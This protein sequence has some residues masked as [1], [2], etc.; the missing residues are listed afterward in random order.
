MTHILE[1]LAGGD[2]RSIGRSNEAV[3][4][5]LEN[6]ELFDALFSGLLSDDPVI[7]MRSADAVE[8]VTAIHPEYLVS[9]KQ[10]LLNT[11]ARVEQ[12]KCAGM[13]HPCW[14][15]FRSR[16]PSKRWWLICC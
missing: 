1:M 11:L 3:A 15:D 7:R 12:R 16:K 14:P 4:L 6:P 10:T 13:W 9:H 8:K 2:R 5:I